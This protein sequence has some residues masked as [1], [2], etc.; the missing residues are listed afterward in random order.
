ML[1]Q[2]GTDFQLVTMDTAEKIRAFRARWAYP[3]MICATMDMFFDAV[4]AE[5]GRADIKTFA[6]DGNNDWAEQ[7]ATDAWLLG[8]ARRQGE[9]VPTAEKFATIAQSLSGGG[10]PWTNVYQAYH[11]LLAYHEHTDAIDHI[12]PERE[13]MRRYETELEENREMVTEAKQFSDRV[14]DGSLSRLTGLITTGAERNLVVFNPLSHG[15][16]PTWSACR[17]AA[18]PSGSR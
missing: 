5:A 15:C 8:L 11:R 13:R 4:A 16:G 7:D 10:Y 9:A 17:P 12:A 18:S 6:K 14:L 3:R 1:L 2:E